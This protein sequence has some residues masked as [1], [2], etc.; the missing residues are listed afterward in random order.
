MEA[1]IPEDVE[2]ALAPV[3]DDLVRIEEV[4]R[5]SSAGPTEFLTETA[6]H[7]ATAGGKRIRPAVACFASSVGE[8]PNEDTYRSAAAIEM[9]HL[10]TL[11]HDDVIDEADLR[12]GVLSVNEKWDNH[13]AILAGDYL[14]ARSSGLAAQ[15]G[16]EV[17]LILA[18]AVARVVGGQLQEVRGTYA[19]D[20]TEEHY[21]TTIAGKTAALLEASAR[22][23]ALCGAAD[24]PAIKSLST[25]G[26]AFGFAFQIVDDLLDL[27]ATREQLGKPPGTDLLEGVYTLPVIYA[28]KE[29]AAIGS[30]LGSR[31]ID[32]DAA[33]EAILATDG[34]SK[35]LA[36]ANEYHSEAI[37]ALAAIEAAEGIDALTKLSEAV[38]SRVPEPKP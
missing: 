31:E 7:L 21:L 32:V 35:A 33:R 14:F 27:A 23:G 29:D 1:L 22:I 8:G 36:R 20:R 9:T 12:R 6:S 28:L 30:L 15:V 37:G 13:V 10:A 34:F 26:R 18:E 19:L 16:G 4:L 3:A 24:D 38:V 5:D 11:Y 2:S 17:P 25:F